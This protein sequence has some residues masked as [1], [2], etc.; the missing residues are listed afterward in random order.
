M[1][2][3]GLKRRQGVLD[4]ASPRVP[5][6]TLDILGAYAEDLFRAI[7]GLELDCGKLWRRKSL[8]TGVYPWEV[9]ERLLLHQPEDPWPEDV[10]VGGERTAFSRLPSLTYI[11][12]KQQGRK[13]KEGRATLLHRLILRV[14]KATL[15]ILGAYA[16]DL[17]RAIFGLELDCGKLWRRKSLGTGVY[18]PE[19]PW[20]V[21][22][23]LL[24]R[25]PEDPW[26]EDP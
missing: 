25:Q 26:P 7:F 18:Q 21:R 23:R 17:F 1:T 19:D 14:P 20:E 2:A 12:R 22:E 16:E 24:V 6:A 8:G 13:R 9:R 3:G 5:K 4:A 11:T 15:D 10:S